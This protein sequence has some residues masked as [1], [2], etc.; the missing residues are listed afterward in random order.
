MHGKFD[1]PRGLLLES[2]RITD[3]HSAPELFAP[4]VDLIF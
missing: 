4:N 1:G 3:Q 2:S